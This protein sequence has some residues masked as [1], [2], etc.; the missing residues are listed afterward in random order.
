MLTMA[1]PTEPEARIRFSSIPRI[2]FTAFTRGKS[3]ASKAVIAPGRF[4][5][6]LFTYARSAL[7]LEQEMATFASVIAT[8]C[9]SSNVWV[10]YK[11]NGWYKDVL[12]YEENR[13]R[14]TPNKENRLGYFNAS[15]IT[16]TVGN[17]QRFYIAAQS[18]LPNTIISFWQMVW[19]ADVYLLV[20]LNGNKEEGTTPYCPQLGDRGLEYQV[21]HQFSQE[22]GHCITTKLR[23]YH[24]PSRRARGVWHLQYPEWGDQGCPSSVGHF[25]GFLEELSSVR[26]HTVSEIPAG[27]NRNPPVLVHC[28]AGVGRTGVTILSDLLLYTLDHNQTVAQYRFVYSLLIYYLKHSRLI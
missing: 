9:S 21:W 27:H 4:P 5:K 26:Q 11:Q 20:M 22:T 17:Q 15:H 13:V 24:A 19:E 6:L 2:I 7:T 10:T 3:L 18:P 28:S 12:P 14:L 23:L 1:V 16:A 25:L 8:V